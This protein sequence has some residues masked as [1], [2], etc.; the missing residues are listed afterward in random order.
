MTTLL[1]SFETLPLDFRSKQFSDAARA[2]E[3]MTGCSNTL[4]RQQLFISEGDVVEAYTVL[5]GGS[6]T[7][8]AE[9]QLH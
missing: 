7:D 6:T 2:L 9:H 8:A 5:L 1:D 3:Q 4:C